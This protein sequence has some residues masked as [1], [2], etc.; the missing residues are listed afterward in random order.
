TSLKTAKNNLKNIQKRLRRSYDTITILKQKLANQTNSR[1]KLGL[2][3]MIST[4]VYLNL[5]INQPCSKYK[6]IGINTY[7][8]K[9]RT[10][11]LL[12]KITLK[13]HICNTSIVHSNELPKV[14]FSKAI[15]GA[16]LVGSVN[17]EEL[18]TILALCRI[19]QQSEQLQYFKKQEE[20]FEHLK[21][22]ANESAQKALHNALTNQQSQ[23]NFTLESH[24]RNILQGSGEFI[25]N[26]NLLGFAHKP[27]VGYYV[28]EKL[29]TYQ[30]KN[31]KTIIVSKGNYNRSSQQMEHEALKAIIN[32]ITPTLEK[33]QMLL[34][35]GIDEDLNSNKTLE[36]QRVVYKICADLKH[37]AKLIR[38]KIE[39]QKMQTKGVVQYLQDNH[40]NCW[41]SVCWHVKNPDLILKEPNLKMVSKNECNELV[42]FLTQ[43]IKL[44]L[45]QSLITTICTSQNE[46]VNHIKLNYTD[47]KTNYPKS[48]SARHVLAILHSNY[49]LIEVLKITHQ[50]SNF[51]EFSE[52]DLINIE[53]IYKQCEEKRQDL[54]PYGKHIKDQIKTHQFKLSFADLI[55]NWATFIKC[56]GCY[57]FPKRFLNGLCILCGFYFNNNL[58]SQIPNKLYHSNLGEALLDKSSSIKTNPLNTIL[59]EVFGFQ[60]YRDQQKES[61]ES[62]FFQ[63]DTLSIMKTDS[64]KT[65]IYAVASILFERLT[66]IFSPLKLLIEDQLLGRLKLDSP[67]VPVLLLIATLLEVIPKPNK[68]EKLL[69]KI[70]ES[71]DTI[72]LGCIIIYSTT[73]AHCNEIATYLASRYG[74]LIIG[75][76][77]GSL[78]NITKNMNLDRWKNRSVKIIKI[79]RATQDGKESKCILF[80][81]WADIQNL[82][83]ILIGGRTN[84]TD[85]EQQLI[86]NSYRWPNDSSIPEYQKY[87]NCKRRINDCAIWYNVREEVLYILRIVDQLLKSHYSQEFTLKYINRDMVGDVFITAKNKEFSS[88]GLS[89]LDE[90][91]KKDKKS[92]ITSKHT[93]LRLYDQ[94][95]LE[96]LIQQNI[97][98][99]PLHSGST[100]L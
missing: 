54:V 99:K 67:N 28:V 45:G 33:F 13:C 68:L 46:A 24:V 90:Y 2:T 31:K 49:G 43:I 97:I 26:E 53:K 88:K 6:K 63:K 47:K 64:G 78:D 57:S 85:E 36:E 20:F 100:T 23:N 34:E 8:Y 66:V 50:A 14:D 42:K 75:K 30:N 73:V 25:Y 21:I 11:G 17:R 59:P 77:H 76:Y 38:T 96:D 19:T 69:E 79:G 22:L 80:F 37:K 82:L 62:F 72:T 41:N 65:L 92:P 98:L 27:I 15:A 9:I 32:D 3:I 35:I 56:E 58:L 40:S 87:D 84:I 83:Y 70:Y 52:Q 93:C 18:R 39:L 51:Q 29:R 95:V 61:I 12:V 44:P 4:E 1:G 91:G 16:G 5:L 94:L 55:P 60:N 81:S 7:N 74:I 86:Y 10:N 89:T 71:L 48:Y